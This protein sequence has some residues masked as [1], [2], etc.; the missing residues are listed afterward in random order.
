MID[1]NNYIGGEW[2]PGSGQAFTSENPANG[3]TIWQGNGASAAEVDGA[4]EEA[5][6]AYLE[7][8]KTSL[9][10][11]IKFLRAYTKIIEDNKDKLAKVISIETG[12]V[13]WDAMSE[14][15]A[16]IGKV[17][18]LANFTAQKARIEELFSLKGNTQ[19]KKIVAE[20]AYI[21]ENS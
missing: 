4:F 15:A 11:R 8:R 1:G 18:N 10:D 12:K 13:L 9:E 16:V 19:E 17:E 5:N 2:T 21:D 14:V 6:A 20:Y 7:W 3:K